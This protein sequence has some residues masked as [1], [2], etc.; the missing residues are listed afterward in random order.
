MQVA[1]IGIQGEQGPQEFFGHPR[2]NLQVL[3]VGVHPGNA[4]QG[5]D[6]VA[7]HGAD[8]ADPPVRGARLDLRRRTVCDEP[9]LMDD[10]DPIRER[11]RFLHVVGG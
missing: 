7:V 9:P 2:Q 5:G 6:L 8:A 1:Q 11:V 3:A 10:H 4:G